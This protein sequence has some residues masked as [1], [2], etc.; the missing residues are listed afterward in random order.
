MGCWF[1]SNLSYKLTDEPCFGGVF[2]VWFSGA[3]VHLEVEIR[4]RSV[5]KSD[6]ILLCFALALA[7]R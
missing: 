2:C 1:E 6:G 5:C 3:R 7:P 4:A